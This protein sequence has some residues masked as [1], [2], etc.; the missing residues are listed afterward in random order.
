M[1]LLYYVFRIRSNDNTNDTFY[2]MIVTSKGM[3][4]KGLATMIRIRPYMD[5]DLNKILQWSADGGSFYSWT[6]GLLGDPP[7]TEEKF[8]KTGQYMRFTAVD[9]KEPVGFFIM[10]HP[11]ESLEEL[12]FGYGIV[13]PDRRLEGIGK[14]MLSQGLTF[15]FEIYGAKRVTLGVYDKN[16][17]GI[18]CYTAIGFKETGVVETYP[19]NGEMLSAIE[20]EALRP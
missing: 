6:F 14:A 9:G 13:A 3:G 8:S 11:N 18:N 1:L 5:S 12:R 19:V 10:R 4:K 16:L 2:G 17:V 20:M 7:L 15:A